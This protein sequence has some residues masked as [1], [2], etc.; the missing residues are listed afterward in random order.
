MPTPP[1]MVEASVAADAPHPKLRA[2]ACVSGVS[3]ERDIPCADISEYIR[4][5]DNLVWL[6]VQDPG[7][8]EAELLQEEF[9]FHPLAVED[10]LH[11]DQRP[12]IDEYKGFLFMVAY[13]LPP[14][15]HPHEIE[16]QEV[17]LFIGRN[18]LVTVHRGPVPALQD[19][20]GR[21]MRGGEMMREGIGFLVYT[22][23]DTMID[24][25]FPVLESIEEEVEEA[26]LR[27]LADNDA[28]RMPSL[29][30][31]K[32]SLVTLRR[33]GVPMRDVFGSL[34]RREQTLFQPQTRI[35]LQDVYDHLLRIVD[36]IET[37]R[38]MLS[39][40]TDAYLAVLSNRL[41]ATMKTLT[42]ITI[43]VALVGAIFGAWGMNFE[44]IPFSDQ[45]YGFWVLLGGTFAAVGTAVWLALRRR[46]L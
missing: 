35:Y 33:L 40:A 9:G 13:A 32:R 26:E 12:K 8:E 18:Y 45:Q 44:N 3:I 42:I 1:P 22:V 46:W 11:A 17:D 4:D 34:L 41:N 5:R 39:S 15:G 10:A 37:E 36:A 30:K 31:V 7:E 38:E 29:L 16:P 19:A 43:I 24:T 14:G 25:Y 23:L 2:I 21:W 6:D 27:L 28:G 20:L